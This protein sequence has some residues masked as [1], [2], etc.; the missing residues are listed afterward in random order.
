MV[1]PQA[2]LRIADWAHPGGRSATPSAL[3]TVPAA[4]RSGRRAER[5]TAAWKRTLPGFDPGPTSGSPKPSARPPPATGKSTTEPGA[6]GDRQT[7]P[8]APARDRGQ[9][10]AGPLEDQRVKLR[11][12]PGA[13]TREAS[14]R[15]PEQTDPRPRP[16]GFDGAAGPGRQITDQTRRHNRRG[17]DPGRPRNHCDRPTATSLPEQAE[18]PLRLVPGVQI[19][20][21]THR[22]AENHAF[23]T[24]CAH[25]PVPAPARGVR[26]DLRRPRPGDRSADLQAPSSTPDPQVLPAPD[27]GCLPRSPRLVGPRV[28]A[29]HRHPGPRAGTQNRGCA[30]SM[31]RPAMA[32]AGRARAVAFPK[33]AA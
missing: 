27:G 3:L 25:L 32:K 24:D 5:A 19:T 2:R 29:G 6:P 11:P 10:V 16:P 33:R 1:G 21:R 30:A 8:T 12:N 17:R 22:D 9:P 23:L 7:E 4:S 26:P 13:A 18:T 31:G 15:T 28:P 14:R 20:D